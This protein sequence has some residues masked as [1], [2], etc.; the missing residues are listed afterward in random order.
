MREWLKKKKK[1][2]WESSTD[3]EKRGNWIPHRLVGLVRCAVQKEVRSILSLFSFITSNSK[4]NFTLLHKTRPHSTYALIL[5]FHCHHH[6]HHHIRTIIL[7]PISFFAGIISFFFLH[8]IH[9]NQILTCLNIFFFSIS[10]WVFRISCQRRRECGLFLFILC[11]KKVYSLWNTLL[12]NAKSFSDLH[13]LVMK[14]SWKFE[15]TLPT[16]GSWLLT[17]LR[18]NKNAISMELS[19]HLRTD[20][21]FYLSDMI[22]WKAWWR[23]SSIM[24]R[25]SWKFF[26]LLLFSSMQKF[27]LYSI[28][29]RIWMPV[30][31]WYRITIFLMSTVGNST[32]IFWHECPVGKVDRQKLLNQQGC[33]VWITGLSG[34]G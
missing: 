31:T 4:F 24:R 19:C 23:S 5:K 28:V 32:N 17:A 3:T 8:S 16:A 9:D 6:H 1:R 30:I 27:R 33:I 25:N 13:L 15:L 22:I 21:R 2:E 10:I 11:P 29:I 14:R 20:S 34:S 18:E 12:I 26:F 7:I